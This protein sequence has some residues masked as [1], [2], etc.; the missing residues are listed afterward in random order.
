MRRATALAAVA[1]AAALSLAG[2][3][4]D[5][6]DGAA[7][8]SLPVSTTGA[9]S[10]SPTSAP[11]A[12]QFARPTPL[13]P[14]VTCAYPP[15]AQAVRPVS[16]P[17]TANISTQGIATVTLDTSVGDIGLNLDRALAPCTVNSMVS[18]STQGYFDDTPC[19]RLVTSGIYV[20][21][22]GDP[23]GKG[24]GGPGYVYA[25]EYPTDL[26]QANDPA[27]STSVNYPRGTVAMANTGKPSSNGSQFF[28]VYQDS[29][30]PPTYTVVG[31]ISEPGLATLD[32]VAAGGDDGSISAGG[33]A[34]K[35][36]VTIEKA[37]AS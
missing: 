12:G 8:A 22:C 24:N 28:L 19:H 35:T 21:Q 15:S 4:S 11:L 30:L 37:T 18:L 29:P 16:P 13:P 7:P 14:T 3:S 26:Y 5:S 6:D 20:L 10:T 32:K 23:T 34:P 27:L 2:C 25:N 31:S 1:L 17:P 33:G 9:P 36:T